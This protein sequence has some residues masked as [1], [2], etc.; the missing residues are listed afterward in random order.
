M[1]AALLLIAVTL[2]GCAGLGHPPGT[3]PEP[4]TLASVNRTLEGNRATVYFVD[5]RSPERLY[6]RVGPTHTRVSQSRREPLH[7]SAGRGAART[8]V[9]IIPTVDIA[10]IEIDDSLSPGQGA[11]RGSG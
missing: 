11:L 4:T 2:S 7:P 5:G 1:R 10:Q 3:L 9:G 6:A 8:E